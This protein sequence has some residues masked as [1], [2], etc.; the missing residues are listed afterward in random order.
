MSLN[1]KRVL[2]TGAG[3]FVG[4]HLAERLVREGAE[5]TALV[6]Y[7]GNGSAG[8]LDES[9][10]KEEIRI[11]P[12][13]VTDNELL[14][15]LA[16]ADVIFHLAAL[17]GIPYSYVA[18]RSYTRVNINGTLNVLEAARD[19][20]ARVI[21]TSTS[22]VYGSAQTVPMDEAH[23]IN[24]QSP[25][26]ASKVGADAL[27]LAYHRSF[28]LSVVT[29]R[30][31]NAMGSRQSTRAVI[32]QIITQLLAGDTVRLGSL[33]PT[34]DLN[35]ID[36]T[37]DGFIAAANAS[38]AVAAGRVFNIGSGREISIE[39]LAYLIGR[40]MGKTITIETDT[41]R[42][43]P[44]DSEVDR[45]CADATLARTWLGWEPKVSLE[46]G[47]RETIAWFRERPVREARYAV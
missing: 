1:G 13:D 14:R 5:V 7:R 15:P 3:G 26:A 41:H 27:A 34:R 9:P 35:Y 2:V 32:P 30:P 21:V 20:G 39:N 4:S 43:R 24:P 46:E 45:L 19:S 17:V 10:F 29:I 16:M 31:F 47:L 22:E 12:G 36:N 18:P 6:H 38:D 42:Q 28:G 8:W 44:A 23:P 11:C 25:Y 33:T 37:V 40:L